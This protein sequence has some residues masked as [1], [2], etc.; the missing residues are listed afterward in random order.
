M[1]GLLF[2]M[3]Q[4]RGFENELLPTN[5]HRNKSLSTTFLVL[6]FPTPQLTVYGRT[7]ASPSP[8]GGASSCLTFAEPPP[9]S[10]GI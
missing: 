1:P 6:L 4:H 2:V 10:S 8:N 3:A 9:V 5:C 7:S